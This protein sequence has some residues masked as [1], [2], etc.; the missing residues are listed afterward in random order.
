MIPVRDPKKATRQKNGGFHWD[1][2]SRIQKRKHISTMPF[3][4]PWNL[5]T[6]CFRPL[7]CCVGWP[8]YGLQHC[9]REENR[10]GWNNSSVCSTACTSQ[11]GKKTADVGTTPL[12]DE[13]ASIAKMSKTYYAF[14]DL[15][16]FGNPSSKQN[17]YRSV[18]QIWSASWS[19]FWWI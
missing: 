19:L 14:T 15:K 7:F 2:T 3:G 9:M 1:N 17:W 18:A 6:V 8:G 11:Q 13:L 4:H 5:L 10:R 16:C 12:L